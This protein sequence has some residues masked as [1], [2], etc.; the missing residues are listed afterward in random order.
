MRHEGLQNRGTDEWCHQ[1]PY[2]PGGFT[3]VVVYS[4]NSINSINGTS[5]LS[6]AVACLDYA[7]RTTSVVVNSC[8]VG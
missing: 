4:I 8:G 7:S 6:R 2:H 3:T 5:L 1:G